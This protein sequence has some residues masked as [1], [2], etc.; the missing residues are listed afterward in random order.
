MNFVTSITS[1]QDIYNE[2]LFGLKIWQTLFIIFNVI[3][4]IRLLSYILENHT[5][6]FFVQV[7]LALV[8]TFAIAYGYIKIIKE[9]R[10]KKYY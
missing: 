2:E 8:I 1:N 10:F 4:Y 5:S 7:L 3:I 9:R 6:Y